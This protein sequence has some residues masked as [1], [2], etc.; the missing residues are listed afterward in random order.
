[1]KI[2]FV[3][4][5]K[6]TGRFTFVLRY[7]ANMIRSWYI[8]NVKF[9]WV[10]YHGFVR[11]MRGTRFAKRTIQLGHKVQFG[12]NCNIAS[13]AVFGNNIL[14]AGSVSLVGKY[15]HSIDCAGV[16]IWDSPRGNDQPTI[17]E[18]DVWIGHGVIVIGGV[19]ISR[20]SVVA[21][22]S[23]VTKS[24]PPCEVW[25]GNPARRIKNRFEKEADKEKHLTYLKSK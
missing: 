2:E 17:I 24:I 5:P 19:T 7:W 16:T 3:N 4:M 10:K 14:L 6:G 9:P 21:A 13:D 20:G 8:F 1:M 11:V 22:G 23:V 25:A 12:P 15:D 18:D